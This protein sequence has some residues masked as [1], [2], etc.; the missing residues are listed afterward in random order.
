[1]C[2]LIHK[3]ISRGTSNYLNSWK[4]KRLLCKAD[5]F[6]IQDSVGQLVKVYPILA[7]ISH[8]LL[9]WRVSPAYWWLP[10]LP[11]PKGSVVTCSTVFSMGKGDISFSLNSALQKL[12]KER[13]MR[14]RVSMGRPCHCCGTSA[15]GSGGW[16]WALLHTPSRWILHSPTRPHQCR[17][18]PAAL[19]IMVLFPPSFRR[20]WL[21]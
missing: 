8:M 1:M 10:M 16:C 2:I 13:G 21:S 15:V 5:I 19:E 11:V 9:L 6:N 7:D 3:Q 14:E 4:Q 12:S 18:L 20:V 17:I